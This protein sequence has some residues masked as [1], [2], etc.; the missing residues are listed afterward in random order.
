M[1][2]VILCR[3]LKGRVYKA[4][5]LLWMSP[6]RRLYHLSNPDS[7][8]CDYKKD[9]LVYSIGTHYMQGI[10]CCLMECD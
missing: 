1:A 4:V 9:C 2:Q 6:Y 3:R 8:F 10:P 5:Y 7:G